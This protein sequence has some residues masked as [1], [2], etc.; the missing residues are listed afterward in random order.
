MKKEK[1][2]TKLEIL[3]SLE[4]LPIVKDT[5]YKRNTLPIKSGSLS[6]D[7]ALGIGGYPSG[8]IIDI[9]GEESSGKSLL[10]I[11]A[12]A[13]VQKNG[14]TVVVWDA[15]RSYSKNLEWMKINGVKTD[16]LRFLK[17]NPDQGAEIGFDTIEKI[18]KEQAADLI[19]IDSI[20][21]LVP[22][23]M[24]KKEIQESQ[25]LGARAY[26][27]T[28][29]LPRLVSLCDEY[30]TTLM[31]INQMRANINGGFYGPQEKE[32]S[33]FALRH[34][35]TIRMHVKKINKSTKVVNNIPV[36]HRV[37]VKIVKNKVAAPFKTAEFEI[38]YYSGVNRLQEI[39]E[40]MISSK[41]ANKKGGWIEY[42]GNKYH[43]IDGLIEMLKDKNTKIDDIL[44][45]IKST[46]SNVFG[47]TEEN[48][49]E[50]SI[51]NSV[52]KINIEDM[53]V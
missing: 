31:T 41:I 8:S 52:E 14:G 21:S 1:E 32:T 22:S 17:L 34:H 48:M 47:L 27:L 39:A 15:E 42:E 44:N 49:I 5:D 9:F 4:G 35:A 43:G 46:N 2:I 26:L 28:N 36:S 10:S 51:T 16:K 29:V 11:M 3:D 53:D 50:E 12:M 25:K 30:N 23:E 38:N 6:L 45:K 13:E 40:I 19:V 33:I 7:F 18:I 20:P 24:L 37:N